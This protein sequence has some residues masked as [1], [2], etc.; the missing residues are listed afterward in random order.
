MPKVLELS[1]DP[2]LQLASKHLQTWVDNRTFTLL[3]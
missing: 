2:I 3:E 1:D